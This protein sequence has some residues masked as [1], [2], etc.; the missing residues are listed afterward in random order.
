MP[1]RMP[2]VSSDYTPGNEEARMRFIAAY[3][4]QAFPRPVPSLQADGTH[5]RALLPTF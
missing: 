5:R 2:P 4:R 1:E 3:E